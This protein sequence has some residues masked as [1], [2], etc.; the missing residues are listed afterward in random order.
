VRTTREALLSEPD[1]EALAADIFR[2]V[3]PLLGRAS[4]AFG[5]TLAAL[6]DYLAGLREVAI[7][8]PADDEGRAALLDVVRRRHVPGTVVA[9]AEPDDEAVRKVPLLADR[10]LVGGR[11]AAYVCRSHVC[12]APVVEPE[13]LSA[14]LEVRAVVA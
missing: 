1:R 6:D 7:V 3:R 5:A 8:V 11:A 4:S 12:E 9:A 10:G 13:V 2:L 14:Q